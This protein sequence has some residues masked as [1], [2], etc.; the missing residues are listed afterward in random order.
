MLT[1]KLKCSTAISRRLGS[2]ARLAFSSSGIT[3][4]RKGTHLIPRLRRTWMIDCITITWCIDSDESR[5]RAGDRSHARTL[6]GGG[7]CA[8]RL[9]GRQRTGSG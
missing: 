6:R 5:L 8:R 9:H 1:M 7:D 4:G 2:L 3:T